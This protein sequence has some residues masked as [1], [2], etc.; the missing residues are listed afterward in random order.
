MY[1]MLIVDDE[2]DVLEALQAVFSAHEELELD[3]LTASSAHEALAILDRER[4]DIL[5]SDICMPGMDGLE[6]QRRVRANWPGCRTIFLSGYT[7][8][9]Y[10]YQ[11]EQLE[12]VSYLLK[13]ESRQRIVDT[14]RRT[15]AQLDEANRVSHLEQLASRAQVDRPYLLRTLMEALISD[16]RPEDLARL[17]R[18]MQPD[19]DPGRPLQ[20]ALGRINGS[21]R[22]DHEQ[23]ARFFLLLEELAKR[24]LG[25]RFQLLVGEAERW[26]ILFLLQSNQAVPDA[27]RQARLMRGSFEAVQ[28][29]LLEQAGCCMAVAIDTAMHELAAVRPAYE[30]LR[31]IL[32]AELGYG[33]GIRLIGSGEQTAG[34]LA[35][36]GQAV[37]M[38]RSIIE[39]QYDRTLSL[40]GLAEQVYLNPS[41]LSRLFRRETGTTLIQ[42]LNQVRMTHACG[43][44]AS[45]NM[46]ISDIAIRTGYESPSYFNQAFKKHTGLSPMA[47]RQQKR[48]AI[49]ET[50]PDSE[51]KTVK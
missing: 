11:A 3:I 31:G 15:I 44:L 18:K 43:L 21:E 14:V 19:F 38:V 25:S 32:D 45:S 8:F 42:Y 41:Y 6:L 40:T 22:P 17:I 49:G 23:K 47:Y 36:E 28:T 2:P 24:H 33:A 20:L 39:Q 46:K 27:A 10:I 13:T 34:I 5:L 37:A 9:T 7:E 26:T 1:R 50:A 48:E 30:R 29:V 16:G 4:L 51:G 12:A 35:D